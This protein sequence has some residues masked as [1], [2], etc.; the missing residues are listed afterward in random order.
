MRKTRIR[1]RQKSGEVGHAAH[2]KQVD[3]LIYLCRHFGKLHRIAMHTPFPPSV[4]EL[5]RIQCM[6]RI[7]LQ[8]FQK[9]L[10]RSVIIGFNCEYVQKFSASV[11]WVHR[12]KATSPI[13]S[14]FNVTNQW[15]IGEPISPLLL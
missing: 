1:E 6:A 2:E 3:I 11:F 12:S 14:T 15:N 8:A 10:V 9:S 4:V 13:V 5:N 7:L